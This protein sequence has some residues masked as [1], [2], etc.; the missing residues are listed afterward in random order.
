MLWY[1]LTIMF[2]INLAFFDTSS[3]VQKCAGVYVLKKYNGFHEFH[4]K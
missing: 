1:K 3:S 4:F 2:Y